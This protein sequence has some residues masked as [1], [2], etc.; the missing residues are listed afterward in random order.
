MSQDNRAGL[1]RSTVA[2]PI[3]PW[4]LRRCQ[5]RRLKTSPHFGAPS[6]PQASVSC[7]A[8]HSAVGWAVT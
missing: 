5:M 2:M 1:S 3:L 6:Q 4:G 7:R 8:I